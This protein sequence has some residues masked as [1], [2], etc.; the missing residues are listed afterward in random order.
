MIRADI[1][2]Q[3]KTHFGA[4]FKVLGHVHPFLG[5][6]CGTIKYTTAVAKYGRL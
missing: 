5:N 4:L 2:A 1:Y 6:D 3:L